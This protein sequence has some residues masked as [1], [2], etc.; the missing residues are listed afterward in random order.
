MLQLVTSSNFVSTRSRP[1]AAGRYSAVCLRHLDGF[2]TQPPEGGWAFCFNTPNQTPAVS[3]RSRPKAAGFLCNF[4]KEF[5][6]VSTR[7]RPKA[8]GQI[9]R[10]CSKI[11]EVSTRSRPKAAG[12]ACI[13]ELLWFIVSTRSR[14]KAAGVAGLASD[15]A[16][17][18]FQHAAARRRLGCGLEH[19]VFKERFNT[20]P[21]EGGW[22]AFADFQ[23]AST[24]STRSRPKAAGRHLLIFRRPRQFQHAAARRRL[25]LSVRSL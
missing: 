2:N 4:P 19:G 22:Q 25:V 15:E 17:S 13:A 12:K 8:A 11:S 6:I 20:Q 18:R 10:E 23:T 16:I 3:T 1:K 21:P 9:M 5:K 7:S 24:V 14:P